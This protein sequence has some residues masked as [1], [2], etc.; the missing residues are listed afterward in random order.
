MS[1]LR[2]VPSK[3][4]VAKF[5]LGSLPIT[6]WRLD[7]ALQDTIHKRYKEEAEA[8]VNDKLGNRRRGQ[9]QRRGGCKSAD[10]EEW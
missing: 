4:V 6:R 3:L 9:R 10:K 7:L 1:K 8:N 5:E 2:A